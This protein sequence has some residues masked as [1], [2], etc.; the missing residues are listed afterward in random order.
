[1]FYSLL[2]G[3]AC[4]PDTWS[5]DTCPH[6]LPDLY[7]VC[8]NCL[9]P[10]WHCKWPIVRVTGRVRS[11]KLITWAGIP[12]LLPFLFWPGL[13]F[14]C[15]AYVCVK[16]T[17]GTSELAMNCHQKVHPGVFLCFLNSVIN[18]HLETCYLSRKFLFVF[19]S[20][21]AS[22]DLPGREPSSIPLL[23]NL[24][25]AKKLAGET[26]VSPLGSNFWNYECPG[27]AFWNWLLID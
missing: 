21:L 26:V 17:N 13:H 27:H 8:P 11:M 5:W 2:G 19:I 6:A 9:L 23:R 10:G 15:F 16:E 12:L 20:S 4:G 25:Y 22:E 1:M 18:Y 24:L 3:T 7:K 14:H